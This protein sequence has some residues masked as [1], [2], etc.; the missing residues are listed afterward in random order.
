M[1]LKR[2]LFSFYFGASCS[3]QLV[4]YILH[5]LISLVEIFRSESDS[6]EILPKAFKADLVEALKLAIRLVIL[7]DSIIGEMYHKI[8]DIC[9]TV[10]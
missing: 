7:L 4:S 9:E 10:F 2:I 6:F 3:D 1:Y 8:I 5:L